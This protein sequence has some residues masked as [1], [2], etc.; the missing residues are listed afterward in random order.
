MIRAGQ[1]H[2]MKYLLLPEIKPVAIKLPTS[3][4]C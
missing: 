3:E 2:M 1:N 4:Y